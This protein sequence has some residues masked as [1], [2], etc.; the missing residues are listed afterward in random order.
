MSTPPPLP[1]DVPEPVMYATPIG[2]DPRQELLTARRAGK[3]V[4][5]AARFAFG[6]AIVIF[7]FAVLSFYSGLPT[8]WKDM[9]LGLGM[10]WTGVE[11][12]RGARLMKRLDL[13]APIRLGRNQIVVGVLLVL[14]SVWSLIQ[15]AM[16]HG[17]T[18]Q[19]KQAM[20]EAGVGA[21]DMQSIDAMAKTATHLLWGSVIAIGVL[22]QGSMA[23]Y[24]FSRERVLRKYLATTPEWILDAQRA[25][26]E[27]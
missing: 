20:A 10:M 17:M 1:R 2:L 15:D 18:A 22:G 24:Y 4:F 25:G 27:I 6:D 5:R 8:D 16:G 11:E 12:Y 3:K 19:I 9:L 7:I 13:S 21:G 14:Y 23:V 26:K